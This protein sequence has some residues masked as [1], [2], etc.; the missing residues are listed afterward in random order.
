MS[1]RLCLQCLRCRRHHR[2]R[3]RHP[4]DEQSLSI[5]DGVF[6][7]HS[8][9]VVNSDTTSIAGYVNV[10]EAPN[11]DVKSPAA[12][13][14]YRLHHL[15]AYML[16]FSQV[17]PHIY[18]SLFFCLETE[19]LER[20]SGIVVHAPTTTSSKAKRL[21]Q[22]PVPGT[23]G[24]LG[25]WS[26]AENVKWKP[27]KMSRIGWAWWMIFV[28]DV[29]HG[30]PSWFFGDR[31]LRLV[32]GVH[33][34]GLQHFEKDDTSDAACLPK[35]LSFSTSRPQSCAPC[36]RCETKLPVLPQNLHMFH[37]GFSALAESLGFSW[38]FQGR[39]AWFSCK[40]F[41]ATFWKLSFII[42]HTVHTKKNTENQFH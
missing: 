35:S 11:A 16:K 14:N 26:P 38:R 13:D 34:N 3:H 5:P 4:H 41:V 36:N 22:G 32:H 17:F 21:F 18:N 10:T 30:I 40:K 39:A 29:L 28:T 19:D 6:Q 31:W 8:K 2:H 9:T 7:H 12:I 20:P 27:P 1:L 33:H 15:P 37:A 42:K 25:V 23:S 24:T